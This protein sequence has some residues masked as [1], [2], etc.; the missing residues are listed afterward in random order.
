MLA[1]AHLETTGSR[2]EGGI[3]TRQGDS[4]GSDLVRYIPRLDL[5]AQGVKIITLKHLGKDIPYPIDV[6]SSVI[7]NRR[8]GTYTVCWQG[9]EGED[10][11]DTFERNSIDI[12]I[13]QGP[14]SLAVLDAERIIKRR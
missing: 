5:W 11:S 1:M 2:P 10:Y 8:R 3:L 6:I 4:L 14:I 7:S 12:K 13:D 9:P